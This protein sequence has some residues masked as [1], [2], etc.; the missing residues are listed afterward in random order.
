MEV[1]MAKARMLHKKIS[2]STQVNRLSLYARL[3]FTWMIAHADDEGRLKGEP[4]YIRA[5]VVPMTTWS[6]KK[7]KIYLDEIKNAGLIYYWEVDNEW[8]IE[9]V[10]WSEYQQIRKDRFERSKLPSFIKENDNQSST[11]EQPADNQGTPQSN[12]SESNSVEFNKS[13]SNKEDIAYKNSPKTIGNILNPHDYQIKSDGQLAAYEVWKEF[14]ANNPK[15]F[16]TT[17]LH[18]YMRGASAHKIREFASEMR[19]DKTIKNPGA[20]FN[21]KVHDYLEGKK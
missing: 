2:T 17:Y 6:F 14:E 20:V 21:K 15:A 10:K 5:T 3:L 1:E 19:Q 7:I 11:K 18:A 13:E 9:F 4:E 8:F 12:I 16:Y